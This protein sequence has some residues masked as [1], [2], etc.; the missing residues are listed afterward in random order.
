MEEN[1]PRCEVKI[2]SQR[3]LLDTALAN[4]PVEE[5][6]ERLRATYP[7]LAHASH[8]ERTDGDVRYVEFL[9]RPGRKG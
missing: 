7:E 8:R 4:R 1:T 3:I 5:I 9:P 6:R 2:G